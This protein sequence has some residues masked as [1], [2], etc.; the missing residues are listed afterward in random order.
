LSASQAS[1]REH[2]QPTALSKLATTPANTNI[3]F[4]IVLQQEAPNDFALFYL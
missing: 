2:L 1:G 3:A 4:A